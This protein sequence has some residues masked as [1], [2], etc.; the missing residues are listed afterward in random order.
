MRL[1]RGCSP[2]G[3]R[4][5]VR[6]VEDAGSVVE[7]CVNR[8]RSRYRRI[9]TSTLSPVWRPEAG[10]GS[11]ERINSRDAT[12]VAGK[13]GVPPA[14]IETRLAVAFVSRSSARWRME[15]C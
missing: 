13:G 4:A 8:G 5:K 7:D 11:L 2:A 15:L 6:C 14:K 1:Q 9:A 10:V 12:W 3:G